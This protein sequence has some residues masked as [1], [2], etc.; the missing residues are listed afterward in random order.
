LIKPWIII[1]GKKIM[2]SV[3][4]FINVPDKP[5]LGLTLNMEAVREYLGE[6]NNFLDS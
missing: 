6:D 2:R 3:N 4:G 1:V 5:G